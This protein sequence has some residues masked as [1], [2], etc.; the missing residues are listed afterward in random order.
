MSN[1]TIIQQGRFT[2]DGNPK[3]IQMRS[4]IDWMVVYNQ[5]VLDAAGAGTGAKFEW[6]RGMDDDTGIEY[7]KT[8]ATNAL[9]IDMLT[10]GG[11]T[12]VDTSASPLAAI[13]TT[14]TG[15]TGATGACT[16]TSTTGLGE[17]SVIRMINPV[18]AQQIGG[19]DFVIDT[20]VANTSFNLTYLPTI[21]NG[22]TFSFR[23]VKWDPIFYPRHRFISSISQAASA[24]VITTV[25]HGY[26]VGQVVRFNV[27]SDFGMTEIDGL[28][29]TITAVSTAANSFTVD[30]DTSAFTAFAW[31]LTT[32][33]PL[34]HPIVN[35]V[36][37]GNSM[38][39]AGQYDDAQDNVSYIG[40]V[41]AA[42]T[43]S[44]AGALNDVIYWQA[45]KVL[46]VNNE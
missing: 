13:Q 20:V 1:G 40:M 11:F 3:T 27:T 2:A 24:V 35:P 43:D 10:S 8:A 39:L 23:K 26:V 34:S 32:A 30:I 16:A 15:I 29:G 31:P 4:D 33:V 18:G 7:K 25:P 5:T 28:T 21:A 44:P 14:G 19:V 6:L 45:G 22:T 12:L 36:G 38:V 46:D 41:L 37:A 17:N 9:Q 42:G